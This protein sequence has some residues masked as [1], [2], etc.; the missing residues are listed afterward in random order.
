[1]RK[2]KVWL[3]VPPFA[4]CMLD[5]T[6]TLLNQ[7]PSYW[8]G[9]YSVAR[10]GNPWFHWLLQQHPLAFEAGIVTWVALFSFLI[11][12]LPR[13]LAMTISIAIVLGHTWATATW[14]Y[15]RLPFGYWL[16]LALF[17]ISAIVVVATW[18]KFGVATGRSFSQQ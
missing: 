10:E 5:Q 17:L 2:Q 1:M 9:D 4:Y 3:C 13:R 11:I 18:E 16:T 12:A 7:S 14:I 8:A 15:W 6:I